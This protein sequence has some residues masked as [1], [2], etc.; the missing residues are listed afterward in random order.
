[1]RVDSHHHVWDLDVRPQPWTD[2]FPLL[3]RSYSLDELRPAATACNIDATVVVQTVPLADETPELLELASR[4]PLV[5]GV[6]GWVDLTAPD[7]SE[8]LAMLRDGPGGS[9]LVGIRHQVQQESEPDWL[10]RETV[11]TGLRAVAA[12]GL[13]YDLVI[14]RDQLPSARDAAEAIPELRFILDHGGN[15]AIELAELEP[16]STDVAAFAALANTAVKLSGLVT[17][18]A[19]DWNPDHLRPYA[20]HLFASFGPARVLF[21]SDW[22]V[23]LLRTSYEQVVESAEALTARLSAG[24]RAAVFGSNAVSWY[25]LDPS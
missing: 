18:A 7:V 12:H 20:D 4:D 17:Q 9:H 2:P 10:A 19:A 13:A 15:P 3:A 22:P 8:K 16:W 24:E 14:R 11:R 6:V 21:G 5:V 23:C 25:R 1:M